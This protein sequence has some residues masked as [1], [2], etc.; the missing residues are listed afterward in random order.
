MPTPPSKKPAAWAPSC[1]TDICL[2]LT[3]KKGAVVYTTAP[4]FCVY[5]ISHCMAQIDSGRM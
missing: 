2:N 1:A 4:F 3:Q 5:F